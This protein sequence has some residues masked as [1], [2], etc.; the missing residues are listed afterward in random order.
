MD[1]KELK[2][3]SREDLENGITNLLKVI[4]TLK[5]NNV[6]LRAKLINYEGL[7]V[8]TQWQLMEVTE[9][10][11]KAVINMFNKN[12]EKVFNGNGN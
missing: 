10:E 6:E 1:E 7:D 5:V 8:R 4:D 12:L 9:E 2:K 11:A 3:Y